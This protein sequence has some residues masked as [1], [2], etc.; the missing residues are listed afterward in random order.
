MTMNDQAMFRIRA[1][2]LQRRREI[3]ERLRRLESG[4]QDLAARDIELEEE[5]QK[6]DLTSLYDRLDQY[7]KEEIEAIDLALCRLAVGSYGICEG[8]QKLISEK[9]LDALPATR[10][11]RKCAGRFEQQRKKLPR[12]REAIA[13]GDVPADYADLSEAELE[14]AIYEHFKDDGRLDLDELE[15]SCRKGVIYLSGTVPSENEH[16][17]AVRILT[18]VMG[19]STIVDHLEITSLP[20]E[21]DD[22]PGA[23]TAP[24]LEAD[25]KKIYAIDDLAEGVFESQEEEKPYMGPDRP[26]PEKG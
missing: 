11:C 6:T 26:P 8:C 20:W 17:I 22:R 25:K 16:R 14:A 3:F 10:L 13:C 1:L 24:P 7:E 21:R 12:A 23:R 19:F 18:D 9:R 2:L 5:A 4:W 15:I